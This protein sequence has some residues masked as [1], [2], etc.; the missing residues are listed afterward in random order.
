MVSEDKP[1]LRSPI[2]THDLC[3]P[4]GDRWL[5]LGR[6]FAETAQRYGFAP[7]ATPVFEDAAV[8]AGVGAATDVVGKQMY[9]F[10]DRSDRRL[11]LRPEGTAAVC[12]AFAQHRPPTP[13]KVWYQ[14][15]FFR[16]EAPQAGRFRQFHQLGAE[17]LGTDDAD[18]DVEIIALAARVLADVGLARVRLLVNS[19]GD[20]DTRAVYAAALGEHLSANLDRLDPDDRA[21]AAAA[22]LR[23]LDSKRPATVAATADAPRIEAFLSPDAAR[24]FDRVRAGLDALG[25]DCEVEPRLVRG[26]DYY[27]RTTF[28]FCADALDSAQNAVC[29]GGRYDGLVEA[30]GGPPTPGIGFAMGVERLLLAC[31]A[32]GVFDDAPAAPAAWVVDVTD[33][34]AARDI[35]EALRAAGIA[36]DRAYDARSMRAQMRAADRS[37]AAAAVIVGEDELAAGTVT[38]R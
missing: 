27:T 38:L 13:W 36:A 33:G 20:G 6:L 7:A 3:P 14:G 12:R 29:G 2:G 9:E 16:Y 17:T 21:K 30:L 26:L 28:E 4:D 37:G 18:A 11:V 5:A 15:P 23:V 10:A 25:I 34:A 8:F 31:D 19:M 35:T 22:P 32:E 1:S 24:H